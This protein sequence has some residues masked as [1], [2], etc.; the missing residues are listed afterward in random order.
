MVEPFSRVNMAN[1]IVKIK[2]KELAE[3]ALLME[4][5]KKDSL[6]MEVKMDLEG[7]FIQKVVTI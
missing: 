4:K 6:L 3:Y 7:Q 2:W 5:Y 1:L